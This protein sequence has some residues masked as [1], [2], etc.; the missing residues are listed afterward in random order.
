MTLS[1]FTMSRSSYVSH[2]GESQW[3][4]K[5]REVDELWKQYLK[6]KGYN[7]FEIYECDWQKTFKIDNIVKQHLRESFP[8]KGPLRE[9]SV[10]EKIK[11]GSLFGYFQCDIKILENLREA[12]AN[13]PS[14]FNNL[15]VD[16][17]G[18]GPFME[19][20]VEKDGV[21]THPRRMLTSSFFLEKGTIITSLLV[22]YLDLGLVCREKLSL[23]PIH[24]NGMLQQSCSTCGDCWKRGRWESK[25]YCY[26]RDNEVTSKQFLWLPE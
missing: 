14:N 4:I 20:Y 24:S 7:V 13:F 10:L 19:Q 25:K 6:E 16:R 3:G 22:F 15:F 9:E 23:C 21:L 5:R 8:Y 1:L 11:Y 26:S 2:W 17:G 12:F 18:I